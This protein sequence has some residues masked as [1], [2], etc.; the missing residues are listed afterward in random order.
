VT[1]RYDALS[2]RARWFLNNFD[3]VDL[4]DLCAE[5]EASNQARQ[6][7]IDRVRETCDRLRRA[8]VLA[9]GQPHGDRSR[10]TLQA[11]ERVL[12]ALD[13]PQEQPAARHDGGPTVRECAEADRRWP[14]EQEGE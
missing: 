10:G 3:E 7:V 9:D 5:Q 12:A 14:L 13:P 4:A 8:N 11:V 2:E 6:E 1:N